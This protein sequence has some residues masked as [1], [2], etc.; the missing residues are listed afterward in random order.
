[1]CPWKEPV[2][3]GAHLFT[4]PFRLNVSTFPNLVVEMV[5]NWEASGIE[6][7]K[8]LLL[9]SYVVW[10]NWKMR[11][12][13]VFNNMTLNPMSTLIVANTQCLECKQVENIRDQEV[14]KRPL[15]NIAKKW[16]PPRAT[17]TKINSDAAFKKETGKGATC[18]VCKDK[19]GRVL[20]MMASQI[21]AYS[22]LV[23]EAVSL[24]EAVKIGLKL[25]LNQVIF[26]SNNF[27]LVEACCGNKIVRE[28][29][30]IVHDI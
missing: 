19:S 24:G 9:F 3:Y 5:R 27:E 14:H 8:L 23:N 1:M 25:H 11:N 7:E 29:E 10:S 30:A 20:T 22:P 4:L 15:V 13:H 2:W 21:Y 28:I 6:V 17:Y 12:D 26:E 16:I 18:V